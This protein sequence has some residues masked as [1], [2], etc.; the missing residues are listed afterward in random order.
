MSAAAAAT[1]YHTAAAWLC[2]A[3][4]LSCGELL[5]TT[6]SFNLMVKK[7]FETGE[8]LAKLQAKRFIVSYAPIALDFRPQTRKTRSISKITCM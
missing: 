2:T 5:H 6:L 8:H 3:K 1:R 4:H 7:N